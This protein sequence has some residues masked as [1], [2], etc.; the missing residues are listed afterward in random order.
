MSAPVIIVDPFSSGAE[1]A[2]AFARR[3]HPAIAVLSAKDPSAGDPAARLRTEDFVQV[4]HYHPGLAETLRDLKP[5]AVL[6]GAE[7]GVAIADLLGAELAPQFGN[8][9]TLSRARRHKGLM[10]EAVAR[11]GL[12]VLRGTYA[13][14][15]DEVQRWLDD[16]GL[17]GAALVVKPVDAMGTDN[18]HVVPPGADWRPVVDL[19]LGSRNKIL[20]KRHDAVVVQEYAEGTEYSVDTVSH[21]GT[22]VLCDVLQYTKTKANGRMAIWDRTEFLPNE[23]PELV[24]Y[25]YGVLD[26]LG[27]RWGAAHSEIMVTADGPRLIETGARMCGGP[28]PVFSRASN[29]SSQVERLVE[30][31]LDGE[32]HTGDYTHRRCVMPVFLIARS[33][34]ILRNVEIF[35]ALSQ[36]DT[37]LVTFI[38]HRNGDQVPATVD[39]HTVFGIVTLSGTDRDAVLADYRRI[40]EVERELSIAAG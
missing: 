10:Y 1:L 21:N 31:V 36:L 2:P 7:D 24:K 40:R 28:L 19:V 5:V 11:A 6:P 13:S 27:I 38:K 12:P 15:A 23:H 18:V 26:A 8:D 35:D 22:H 17:D 29:G 34:G 4:H 33:S 14:D 32:V 25:A 37:H 39:F 30:M 20:G 3:G 9:L 16:A